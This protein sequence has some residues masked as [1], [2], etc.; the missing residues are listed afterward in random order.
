VGAGPES[1]P[2]PR[3]L[4]GYQGLKN[5]H[6]GRP[7]NF[8]T[9]NQKVFEPTREKTPRKTGRSSSK[10]LEGRLS[11]KLLRLVWKQNKK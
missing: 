1:T 8:I 10:E 5:K 11:T 6:Q 9:I 4:R 7:K 2:P 3:R